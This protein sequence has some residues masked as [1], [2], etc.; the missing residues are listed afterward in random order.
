MNLSI[1]YWNTAGKRELTALALS[2]KNEYDII[3]IQEPWV[4][5]DLKT[6]HCPS[7]GL[8]A[9]VRGRLVL[10]EVWGR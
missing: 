7:R 10:C 1:A 8:G 3:A 2:D 9:G 5:R 6:V 4:H